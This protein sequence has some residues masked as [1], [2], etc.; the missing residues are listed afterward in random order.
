MECDR[1]AER[2]LFRF[3]GGDEWIS[4]AACFPFRDRHESLENLDSLFL[5]GLLQDEPIRVFSTFL[6]IQSD[7]WA[8]NGTRRSHARHQLLVSKWGWV[9]P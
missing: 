3:H 7:S 6:V 5:I 4:R 9:P 1:D 8:K 2:N